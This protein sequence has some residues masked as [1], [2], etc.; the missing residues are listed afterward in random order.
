MRG[1]HRHLA[2]EFGVVLVGMDGE[3]FLFSGNLE[4][5]EEWLA[6]HG[7]QVEAGHIEL[8]PTGVGVDD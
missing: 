1:P 4:S 8:R 5:C 7:D 6:S 3:T 2:E